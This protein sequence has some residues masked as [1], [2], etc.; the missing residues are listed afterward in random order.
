MRGLT[1]IV[2]G[3]DGDR[4]HAALS[5]AA[6]HVALGGRGRLFLQAE[7]VTLLCPPIIAAGDAARQAA[8]LATL[9]QMLLEALDLGVE[10]VVCQSGLAMSGLVASELDPR[11]AAEGMIGLLTDLGDDRLVIA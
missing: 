5:L 7:A 6:A 9:D 11:I 1:I 3:A 10:L 4:L 2:A 8:G